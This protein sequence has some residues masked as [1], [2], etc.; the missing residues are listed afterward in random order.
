MYCGGSHLGFLIGMKNIKF[1]EDLQMIIHGQ[2]G[3]N[4]PSGFRE[5]ALQILLKPNC[6]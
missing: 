6:T 4:C 3:F 2:F 1:I 5:V